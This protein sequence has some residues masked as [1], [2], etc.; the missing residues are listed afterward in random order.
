[1]LVAVAHGSRDPRSAA[2]IREL[3][4]AL[5]GARPAFLDLSEPLFADVLAELRARGQR[6]VVVVPLLLG[7]AYHALVDIPRIVAGEPALSTRVAE[8]IGGDPRIVDAALARL[9]EVGV[10]PGD[11]DVGVVLAG[12]GSSHPAANAVVMRQAANWARSHGWAG[13]RAAFAT[14]GFTVADAVADLRDHGARRIAVA[15]WF[16]APGFLPDRVARQ[17]RQ[18]DP[19]AVLAAPLGAHPLV[20]AAVLD[21]HLPLPA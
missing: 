17:A 19:D 18:A 14:G 7:T 21:R 5:P 3:V 10:E 12:A 9:A 13:V 15:S 1:M 2:V 8:V 4:A 6:E 16:L 11:H 20:V